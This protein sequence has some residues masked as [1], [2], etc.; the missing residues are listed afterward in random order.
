MEKG[1]KLILDAVTVSCPACRNQYFRMPLQPLPPGS[2]L[3]C[4]D[5][6]REVYYSELL[7]QAAEA[8]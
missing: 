6:S 7:S 1:M 4:E 2:P 5:C 8:C 3:T